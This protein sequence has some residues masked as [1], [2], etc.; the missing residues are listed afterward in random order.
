MPILPM[1]PALFFSSSRTVG[2][3][4]D[5]ECLMVFSFDYKHAMPSF[6]RNILIYNCACKYKGIKYMN[7]VFVFFDVPGKV[8]SN[9]GLDL[10][11]VSIHFL[12]YI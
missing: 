12:P 4:Q 11:A 7:Y 5:S 1:D 3:P 9:Q 10:L 2:R 8:L 6:K